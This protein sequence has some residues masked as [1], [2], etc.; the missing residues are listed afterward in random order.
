MKTSSFLHFEA[1]F[2]VFH[3]L[4]LL[5]PGSPFDRS[6]TGHIGS[7]KWKDRDQLTGLFKTLVTISHG[8]FQLWSGQVTVFWQLCDLTS[9]H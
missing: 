7:Q 5:G 2:E 9:K 1:V 6:L 3:Y 4:L 8:L